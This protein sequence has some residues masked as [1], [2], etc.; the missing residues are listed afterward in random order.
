MLNSILYKFLLVSLL[1]SVL[2]II[3][4]WRTSSQGFHIFILVASFS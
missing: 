4:T 2:L 3:I 1:V